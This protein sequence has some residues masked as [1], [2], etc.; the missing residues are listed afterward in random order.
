MT[1]DALDSARFYFDL[2]WSSDRSIGASIMADSDTDHSAVHQRKDE[3]FDFK[4][5]FLELKNQMLE[6][7]NDIAEL[8]EGDRQSVVG[9]MH[10][11]DVPSEAMHES[12]QGAMQDAGTISETAFLIRE[13]EEAH[14]KSES[15]DT[16]GLWETEI[17]D[18]SDLGPKI[19]DRLAI[20]AN[21]RFQTK[22]SETER[23]EKFAA[24]PLPENCLALKVPVLNSEIV[25]RASLPQGAKRDDARLAQVQGCI[26][27]AAAAAVNC[28]S[29]LHVL[30]EK[31]PTNIPEARA[32]A[33]KVANQA[34]V[35]FKDITA[36]LGTA[37]I[38]ISQR[39]RFQLQKSLPREWASICT[40][41]SIP[42][43]DQLFGGDIVKAINN[44]KESFKAKRPASY[45]GNRNHPY[46]RPKGQKFGGSSF[47][48]QGNPA[49]QKAGF[50][51]HQKGKFG[52][53]KG[54][55]KGRR[56]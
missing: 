17:N 23:K 32:L 51:N 42:I 19:N 2:V 5:C 40:N 15:N 26:S 54:H 38:D 36:I 50:S 34:N 18:P 13:P 56:Y 30:T 39:R 12:S 33:V 4:Q 6:M 22:L 28:A 14:E 9:S 35:A 1:F 16:L 29:A 41:D 11:D 24:H 44:A 10:S 53:P 3:D 48:G 25:D 55:Q 27:K 43:S 37:H 49:F 8:K 45:S 31:V 20:V 21:S 47:L 7:K 52:A 46:Q